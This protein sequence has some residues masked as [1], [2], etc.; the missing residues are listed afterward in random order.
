MRQQSNKH[1]IFFILFLVSITVE[2]FAQTIDAGKPLTVS[3]KIKKTTVFYETPFVDNNEEILTDGGN[4][5]KMLRFGKEF[6]VD[7]DLTQLAIQQQLPN[8]STH[9]QF[10][11]ACPNAVSVNLIFTKFYLATGTHLFVSD[12]I[13]DVFIGA[14]SS[15]NNNEA[16]VLGTEL[17]KSA[18]IIVE[19]VEEATHIGSTKLTLGT[20]VHGYR[21]LNSLAKALNSSG[22]CHYDVNC[23]IGI[24]WSNERN[25]VAMMVNG[26]GFC[27]G[28]LVN[29]T[30]GNVIPYFLTANHCGTNPTGW[31]FRFR[32][33]RPEGQ[34]VCGSGSSSVNGPEFM[35]VN[36]GVLR[37]SWSGSDFTL[38]ELN[39][40]PD[41]AWGIYY[42]GWDNTGSAVSA[43]TGIHHP[44]GDIKK[45]SIENDPLTNGTWT[46]TPQN[47]HWHVPGWDFGVTE[48][49][50]SGSPLF[51][52]N[53]HLIGQLHGGSS[54]CGGSDLSDEYGKFSLSWTGN[55]TVDSRLKDWLDPNNSGALVVEGFNPIAPAD[56]IDASLSLLQGVSGVICNAPISASITLTNSGLDTLY[57]ALISYGFDGNTNQSIN[58]TGSLAQWESAVINIPDAMLGNGN[59]SFLAVVNLPNGA[60]DQNMNNDSLTS[61]FV[62]VMNGQ[63]VDLSLQ[64][65]CWASE[66]SWELLDSNNQVLYSGS[67]YADNNPTIIQES[68]CLPEGCYTFTL[69]DQFGDGMT[70]CTGPNAINGSYVISIDSIT[71]C[72]LLPEQA[73]FGPSNIQNFCIQKS[74][75]AEKN[76]ISV[77]MFPNPTSDLLT[78]F[79][80]GTTIEH[81]EIMT[82]SG[83]IIKDKVVD[84]KQ[85]TIDVSDVSQGIYLVHVS[86][87]KGDTVKKL[88]LK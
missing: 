10:G 34:T 74:A 39:S 33:E 59:H 64:L 32:W 78:I 86:S 8:G 2:C 15:F 73:N 25:A 85:L 36:G 52:Q 35:N 72:Q 81:V 27:T 23:P 79:A 38:V 45:I 7:L 51:D 44:A 69:M 26:G 63:T 1:C 60:S 53:H 57:S 84:E 41:P 9:Y 47:S 56:T 19:W 83:Q 30:S 43:A 42:A 16:M 58:W 21:D 18:K 28:T 22:N 24:N 11:I 5:E 67:G 71:L 65:D 4:G 46:G 37:A 61:S 17:V 50:S 82:L 62:M 66:T 20:I 31:V 48:G 80:D 70:G 75:L 88:V 40:T 68:F 13:N 29:N 14:Y 77:L 55:N 54:S 87:S 3:G 76:M 49:G 6:D 12:A